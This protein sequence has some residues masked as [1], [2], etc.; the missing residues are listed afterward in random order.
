MNL[1]SKKELTPIQYSEYSVKII[2]HFTFA[3]NAMTFPL[4]WHDRVELLRIIK[5]NLA[6]SCTD[7]HSTLYPG[8]VAI[9][10]PRMLHSGIAGSEGVV[11]DVIMFDFSTLVNQTAP[12]VK[13]MQPLCDGKY[14]FEPLIRNRQITARLDSIVSAHRQ[15][16]DSHPLQVIGELYD[17]VGLLY[18]HCVIRELAALPIQKHFDRTIDYI[19]EHYAENISS[20]SLSQEFGYEESY[21]CRKFKKQT[22]LTVMKYI[23]ILRMEKARRLL[24]D[25]ELSVQDISAS[26]GFSDTAYFTNRFKNLYLTTPT[27][28]REQAKGHHIPPS[29]E[30]P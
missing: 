30:R 3:P 12:A 11:Y 17:L 29:G 20:A 27:K 24:V 4:H 6:L 26:C 13:Y 7:H 1:D 28:M 19:N 21:F 9:I 10:S 18:R 22:G 14:I 16:G 5:G 25:T 23:Q 2:Y 15:Q 8:D